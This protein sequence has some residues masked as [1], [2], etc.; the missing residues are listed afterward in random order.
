MSN[1]ILI[2]FDL[3]GIFYNWREI[4]LQ[5]SREQTAFVYHRYDLLSWYLNL[6][7][8]PECNTVLLMNFNI[9]PGEV[10]RDRRGLIYKGKK[11]T[12]TCIWNKVVCISFIIRMLKLND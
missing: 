7:Y 3:Y 2:E 6:S 4:D 10:N 8:F 5:V 1:Y 12:H 9:S 11:T